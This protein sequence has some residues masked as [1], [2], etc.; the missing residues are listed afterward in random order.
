MDDGYQRLRIEFVD[1]CQMVTD[2]L[3]SLL[4]NVYDGKQDPRKAIELIRR[5][6]HNLKGQGGILGYPV[7]SMIA[8][9]LED[10]LVKEQALDIS[11]IDDINVYL[12]HIRGI[13]VRDQLPSEAEVNELLR[14]LPHFGFAGHSELERGTIFED[15][16]VMMVTSSKLHRQRLESALKKPGWRLIFFA[17][18]LD[19]LEN[20][21]ASPPNGVIV[22]GE[23][24]L[25]S[26]A[27]L[28]RVFLALEKLRNVP[29][30]I[31]T[32]RSKNHKSFVSL[33]ES[34]N[35]ISTGQDFIRDVQQFIEVFSPRPVVTRSE[36]GKPKMKGGRSGQ[37]EILL[38]EDNRI[39]QILIQRFLDDQP[40]T[41][42]L[43]ENGVD[44]L[45][46]CRKKIF[47][48]VLMDVVMPKMGG[49]E[50]TKAIRLLDQ[51][52]VKNVPI[53]ALTA[54]YSAEHQR[55]Y[56][57]AG[58]TQ[59]IGKPIEPEILLNVIEKLTR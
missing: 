10:Y 36:E 2:E 28:A 13:V 41:V 19:L 7:I 40:C 29:V 18:T 22:S 15:V 38:A 37:L 14:S 54:D 56:Q 48:I 26:G 33:I 3:E 42:T 51:S 12:D 58:M 23:L 24:P 5:E 32:S 17:R 1:Q 30:A 45:D 47:D 35:L 31:L 8:H 6:M 44:A 46:A 52:W 55:S 11:R 59:C 20:A 39:N 53:I 34:V 21:L 25:V 50:A 9:R 16:E 49:V 57:K 43:V 4:N 27:E